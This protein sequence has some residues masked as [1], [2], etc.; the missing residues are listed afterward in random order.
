MGTM[1]IKLVTAVALFIASASI[2]VGAEA[3]WHSSI[4]R[5]QD[6][7]GYSTVVFR[8]D[9]SIDF[10]EDLKGLTVSFPYTRELA[11]KILLNTCEFRD[12]VVSE[13]NPLFLQVELLNVLW[14]QPDHEKLFEDLYQ[15]GNVPGKL[16]ALIGLYDTHHERFVTLAQSLRSAG[17][18]VVRQSGCVATPVAVRSIVDDIDNGSLPGAFRK[19]GKYMTWL[20]K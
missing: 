11:F 3:T 1:S 8:A 14:H 5:F 16:Y 13:P 7:A 4:D 9:G 19:V 6:C 18:E 20:P 10:P 15:R 17:G 2:V 12:H